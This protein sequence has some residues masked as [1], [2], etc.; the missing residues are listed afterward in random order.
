MSNGI[1]VAL[2]GQIALERR[3]NTIASNIANMNTAGYRAEEVKF[4]T[5]LANAGEGRVSF[6]SSGESFISRRAG[7]IL[8]TGNSLDVAVDGDGWLALAGPSGTIYT[9]DG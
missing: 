8:P 6:V 1:A 3:L 7:P 2:S 4:E 9:R 5:L